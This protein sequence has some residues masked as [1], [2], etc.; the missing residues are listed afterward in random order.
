MITFQ[1]E[2]WDVFWAEAQKLWLEHYDEVGA[3]DMRPHVDQGFYK[4]LEAYGQL[5]INTVREDGELKGYVVMLVRK[6]PHYAALCGF[7]DAY[8]LKKD[9][10]G[11]GVGSQLI[12]NALSAAKTRG[13]VKVFFHSKAF[14][15]LASL[16]ARLGFTHSDEL[17]SKGL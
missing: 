12:E 17:W 2:S 10:R 5:Q 16:F 6:H 14:L 8:F 13:V 7:E 15:P 4:T 9:L 1:L 3:K 11:N